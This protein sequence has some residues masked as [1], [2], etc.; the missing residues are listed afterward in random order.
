M[1]ILKEIKRTSES[2]Y[3]FGLK[4]IDNHWAW[5]LKIRVRDG[6]PINNFLGFFCLDTYFHGK[7][8]NREPFVWSP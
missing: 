8:G 1:N 6:H 2:D 5:W 4:Y 7:I 3:R